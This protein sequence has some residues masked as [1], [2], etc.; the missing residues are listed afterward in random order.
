[1]KRNLSI[2]SFSVLGIVC[3]TE[4]SVIYNSQLRAN[5]DIYIHIYVYLSLT[6]SLSLS[7]PPFFFLVVLNGSS[8]LLWKGRKLVGYVTF[9]PFLKH[10]FLSLIISGNEHRGKKCLFDT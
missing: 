8:L 9:R 5:I 7:S 2:L 10:L 1:M 4:S 3:I 6:L